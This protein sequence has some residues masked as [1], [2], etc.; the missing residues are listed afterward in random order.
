MPY[1]VLFDLQ[2]ILQDQLRCPLPDI[3]V[4]L[5]MQVGLFDLHQRRDKIALLGLIDG[6]SALYT[7]PAFFV[8]VS[9]GPASLKGT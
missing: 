3:P 8:P 5:D 7:I 1:N 9:S 6:R 2:S 4:C